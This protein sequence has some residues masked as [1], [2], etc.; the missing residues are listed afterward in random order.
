MMIYGR[1]IRNPRVWLLS[2]LFAAGALLPAFLAHFRLAQVGA[3][4]L[5]WRRERGTKL[6]PWRT[7]TPWMGIRTVIPMTMSM[8]IMTIMGMITAM[9]MMPKSHTIM[10]SG[11]AITS[12]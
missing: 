4:D 12:F 7:T 8:A 1:P 3:S 5:T 9:I 6:T 10:A 11:P 2:L